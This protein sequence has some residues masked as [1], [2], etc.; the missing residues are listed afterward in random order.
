MIKKLV[1]ISVCILITT[2]LFSLDLDTAFTMDT[3]NGETTKGASVLISGNLFNNLLLT[4]ALEYQNANAYKTYTQVQFDKSIITIG[5]GAG[6]YITETT[7]YPIINYYGAIK[8]FDSIKF[9]ATQ[10]I[11]LNAD[12]IFSNILE[13]SD[14]DFL[15]HFYTT[16]Y[17]LIF[18]AGYQN[19]TTSVYQKETYTG[20]FET[21]IRQTGVP[22]QITLFGEG[23]IYYY[24]NSKS[25]SNIDIITGGR[26]QLNL[27]SY[28]SYYLKAQITALSLE[29]T[30]YPFSLSVGAKFKIHSSY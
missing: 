27:D 5:S 15:L 11:S 8:P 18:N 24:D 21:N 23:N 4:S 29:N 28:S 13:L 25:F 9:K 20:K 3:Y 22:L 2:N 17:E 12:N 10:T 6:F 30:D 19:H 14:T 7:F 26:L 16:D 1:F